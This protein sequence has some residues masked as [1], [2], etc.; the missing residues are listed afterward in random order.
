M[1]CETIAMRESDNSSQALHHAHQRFCSLLAEGKLTNM[2]G[3]FGQHRSPMAKPEHRQELEG[4]NQ[5][6]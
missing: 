2:L 5:A 4:N 6:T 1:D 3:H